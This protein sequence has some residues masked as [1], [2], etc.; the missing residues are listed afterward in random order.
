[1]KQKLAY[2]LVSPQEAVS[3]VKP[4]EVVLWAVFTEPASLIEAFVEQRE[5]LSGTIMVHETPLLEFPWF[6]PEFGG[7]FRVYE[8]FPGVFSRDAVHQGHVAYVPWP[9]GLSRAERAN[10]PERQ[11]FYARPDVYLTRVTEPDEGGFV[12]LGTFPWF[13]AEMLKTARLVIGEI[14][15]AMPRT[16]A[17][18][19]VSE[20]DVLVPPAQS[21]V[22]VRR[23][24]PPTP[25]AELRAAEVIGYLASEYIQD[26]FTFQVGIG[27]ASESM[28]SFLGDRQDLGVHSE[29]IFPSIVE[30]V[31]QGVITGA[32]KN[33]DK[34]KVVCSGLYPHPDDP[35]MKSAIEY[36]AANPDVFDFRP[37]GRVANVKV[38]AEHENIVAVNNV[39]ACDLT[40]QVVV[41]NL[42]PKPISGIGGN[43]DFTVGVH[44]A[45]GGRSLHCLL[46]TAREGR[47][48]RIVP[49][50][51]EGAVVSIPRIMVDYL[52]TEYGVVNLEG[53]S[54]RERSRAI[55]SIAHPDFRDELKAAARRLDLL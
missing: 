16:N 48:S 11:S 31:R 21:K 46:S 8:N 54:L 30:L 28:L 41:N 12:S 2:D 53:K 6:E 42:G 14:D 7:F 5:R 32:R 19:H 29:L 43:F 51:A 20:I 38:V 10:D 52:V 18:V 50:H 33:V 24:Q 9:F 22:G 3:R 4:G 26:G 44:Y 23:A 37:I 49:Q 55:I 45:R 40:G 25:E 39:L 36:I 47:F 17:R 13:H 34:G 35:Q 1:M 15:P 27:P